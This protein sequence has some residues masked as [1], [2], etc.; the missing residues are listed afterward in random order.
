[1]SKIGCRSKIYFYSQDSQLHVRRYDFR[2]NHEVRPD[3]VHFPPKRRRT[4]KE[5]EAE[6]A[7]TAAASAPIPLI[8][9]AIPGTDT[10]SGPLSLGMVKCEAALRGSSARILR[11]PTNFEFA[12]EE[13]DVGVEGEEVDEDDEF[14]DEDDDAQDDLPQLY[15]PSN[16]CGHQNFIEEDFR[17]VFQMHDF[18]VPLQ[19][20]QSDA[21]SCFSLPPGAYHFYS[22]SLQTPQTVDMST[23]SLVPMER[24]N[25]ETEEENLALETTKSLSREP[26]EAMLPS[27]LDPQLQRLGELASSCGPIRFA[28]RLRE[29][30]ALGDKWTRENE[31]LMLRS[32]SYGGAGVVI[33]GAW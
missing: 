26:L 10:V 6:E 4:R 12:T 11:Q 2:H 13:V 14:D 30:K 32:R 33:V 25:F 28:S 9:T 15:L 7:A 31:I 1:T 17:S 21:S 22:G 16:G 27:R 19:P 20:Q 23:E 3:L 29:L 5:K 18:E 8:G 24:G